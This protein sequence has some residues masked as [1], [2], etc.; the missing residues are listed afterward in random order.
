MAV[1]KKGSKGQSVQGGLDVAL[2]DYSKAQQELSEFEV[3][4]ESFMVELGDLKTARR[5]AQMRVETEALESSNANAKGR[6]TLTEGHGYSVI[7]KVGGKR[8][9][10]PIKLLESYPDIWQ[11]KGLF[12]VLLG[13]FDAA[14]ESK[15]IDTKDVGRFVS[16]TLTNSVEIVKQDK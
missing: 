4:H 10:D 7:H 14:V 15:Q 5:E 1:R 9:V 16:L 13:K 6:H 11:W 8:K 12:S 3:Q 2:A